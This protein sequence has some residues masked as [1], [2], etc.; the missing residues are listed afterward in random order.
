LAPSPSILV[1]SVVLCKAVVTIIVNPYF[2]HVFYFVT[3][4]TSRK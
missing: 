2:L 4:A 3:L 1:M